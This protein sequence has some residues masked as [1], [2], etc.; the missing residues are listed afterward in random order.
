MIAKPVRHILSCLLDVYHFHKGWSA[1]LTHLLLE[2][3]AAIQ[4]VL[5]NYCILFAILANSHE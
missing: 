4:S 2:Y 5:C 1:L 3:D